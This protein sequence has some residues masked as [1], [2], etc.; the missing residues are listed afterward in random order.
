MWL[1]EEMRKNLPLELSFTQEARNAEKIA[2]MLDYFDWLKIP[3]VVWELTTD[4]VLTM[5]FCR[6]GHINDL[7]YL[8][9]HRIDPIPV[10][11]KIS[12]MYA[13]MIFK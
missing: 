12:Q 9:R 2:S 13:D 5:E 10:S 4:R 8:R 3:E 6:G 7:E 1:A 11:S